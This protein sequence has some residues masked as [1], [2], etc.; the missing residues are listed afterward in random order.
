MQR[1][2]GARQGKAEEWKIRSVVRSGKSRVEHVT[3]KLALGVDRLQEHGRGLGNVWLTGAL[4]TAPMGGGGSGGGE[5]GGR[6][7]GA[8]E[9]GPGGVG[10]MEKKEMKEKE[11]VVMM[12]VVVVVMVVSGKTEGKLRVTERSL[13]VISISGDKIHRDL[14]SY[15]PQTATARKVTKPL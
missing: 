1:R 6:G 14:A 2:C 7:G 8:E 11:A 15:F 9:W 3:L 5:V 13:K 4:A 12:V 10:E